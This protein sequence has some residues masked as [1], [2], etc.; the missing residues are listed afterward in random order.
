MKG[1]KNMSDSNVLKELSYFSYDTST[2]PRKV[3]HT[4]PAKETKNAPERKLRVLKDTPQTRKERIEYKEKQSFVNT[5]K[6]MAVAIL[7]ILVIGSLVY[8]RVTINNIERNIS[9]IEKQLEEAKSENIKLNM[10]KEALRTPKIISEFAQSKG[11]IQ[12]DGYTINYFDLSSED[13][14]YALS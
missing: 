10:K 8:Q 6:I 5:I 12:R 2:S 11:M 14:G 9:T 4:S 3:Q 13:I 7:S 1:V